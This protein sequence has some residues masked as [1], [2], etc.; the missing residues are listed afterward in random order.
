MK[1]RRERYC[2]V[3]H[4][5]DEFEGVE[6]GTCGEDE[7]GSCEREGTGK[8]GGAGFDTAEH[9]DAALDSACRQRL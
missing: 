2:D 9:G 4:R 3:G 8:A 6:K 5:F 7:D 1:Q